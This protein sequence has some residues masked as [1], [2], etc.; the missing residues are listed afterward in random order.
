MLLQ[1]P[2][3]WGYNGW[4]GELQFILVR[5][6]FSWIRFSSF[7]SLP[8][9]FPGKPPLNSSGVRV[10]LRWAVMNSF[11]FARIPSWTV[12][13]VHQILGN[14]YSRSFEFTAMSNE[15]QFTKYMI[16]RNILVWGS[17]ISLLKHLGSV[18]V[19]RLYFKGIYLGLPPTLITTDEKSTSRN[20]SIQWKVTDRMLR[21]LKHPMI[22]RWKWSSGLHIPYWS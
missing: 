2:R 11:S 3:N 14:S 20:N 21:N 17:C 16:L 4:L 18:S 8:I 7:P 22:V 1:E 15:L 9:F 5:R 12:K 6:E 10:E 19:C 13:L